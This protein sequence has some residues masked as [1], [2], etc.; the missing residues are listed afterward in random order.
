MKNINVD[1]L[2]KAGPYSHAVISGG[3]IFVSGQIGTEKGKKTGFKEQFENAVRKADSI[4]KASG[5][6]LD[7]AVKVVV[8]LADRKYFQEMNELFEK[9]FPHRPSRTTVVCDFIDEEI[10]TEVDITAEA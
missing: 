1:S 3:L 7:R 6:S 10:L 8:Y 4:L 5:S 2:P 9:Y